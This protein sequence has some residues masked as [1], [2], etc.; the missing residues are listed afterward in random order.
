MPD[1]TLK[2]YRGKFALYYRENGVTKRRSTGTADRV[3][4]QR[5]KLEVEAAERATRAPLL[6]VT[7]I[8]AAYRES[9]V[10]RPTVSNMEFEGRSVLPFFGGLLP[11]EIDD[12][13]CRAYAVLRRKA[14]RK[15][16][17]IRT[18]LNRLASALNWA[19]KRCLIVAAPRIL[20]PSA[21]PPRER[22][23]SKDEARALLAACET[24][25]LRLFT[26]L[27]L[28][29]GART[30]A[31]LDL[32]WAQVDLDRRRIDYRTAADRPMKS[33][34]VAPLNDLAAS[35]L[36]AVDH[37]PADGYVVNWQG[38]KV[39]SIKKAFRASCRRAGLIGVSPH[40]LRHTAAVWMAESRTSMEQIAQL[41]GHSNSRITER[42]YAR[43]SPD[44]LRGAADALVF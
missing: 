41:L 32:T 14:G 36:A 18:E 38:A 4:A 19:A 23:L 15:D 43:F 24:E 16:G 39:A 11:G 27:A 25:H 31:I 5:I 9:L 6:T 13:R 35:A 1:Y 26:I 22:H 30:Q 29:T 34:V 37:R 21:P 7:D 33:K 10:G 20:R 17:A 12:A 42:V 28:T 3:E 40:I 8:W 44:Y 2:L